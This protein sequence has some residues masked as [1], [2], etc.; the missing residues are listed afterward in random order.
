LGKLLEDTG[1]S[2]YF[3]NRTPV[4]HEIIIGKWD[5]IKLQSFCTSKE[6][7]FRIKRQPTEWKK[8]FASYSLDKGLASRI[9]KELNKNFKNNPINK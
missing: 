2:K 3:L 6:T 5:C 1:I 8:I 9:Y 7:I 4:T